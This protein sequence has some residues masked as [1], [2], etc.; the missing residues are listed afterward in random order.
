MARVV[1]ST[2]LLQMY[3]GAL[4]RARTGDKAFV[5]DPSEKNNHEVRAAIRRL[6]AASS[7]CP[8]SFRKKKETRAYSRLVRRLYNKT[9][10]IADMDLLKRGLAAA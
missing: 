7:L 4:A 10:R 5:A 2:T 3:K 6:D 8:K 1:R 9:T